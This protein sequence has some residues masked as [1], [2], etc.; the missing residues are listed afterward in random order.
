M[1]QVWS[2]GATDRVPGNVVGDDGWGFGGIG[3]GIV[4]EEGG[5]EEE[6]GERMLGEG[7][8]GRGMRVVNWHGDEDEEG[9]CHDRRRA[10]V[11]DRE[12]RSLVQSLIGP[13][14]PRPARPSR[15]SGDAGVVD[16]KALRQVERNLAALGF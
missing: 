11:V 15:R 8:R 10:E 12:H 9:Q 6:S 14:P 7:R 13:P 1:Q 5:E 16:V 2:F 3:I 4:E